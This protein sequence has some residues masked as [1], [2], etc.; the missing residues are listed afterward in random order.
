MK[1]KRKASCRRSLSRAGTRDE[2]AKRAVRRRGSGRGADPDSAQWRQI[3][4]S[5]CRGDDS[6]HP[7]RAHA[8][9]AGAGSPHS[10]HNAAPAS[11]WRQRWHWPGFG[12]RRFRRKPT[13][14][15]SAGGSA[16]YHRGQ[17]IDPPEMGD[18]SRRIPGRKWDL[19]VPPEPSGRMNS[20]SKSKAWGRMCSLQ[21]TPI[22]VDSMSTRNSISRHKSFPVQP[23][24]RDRGT[25]VRTTT[26]RT[27]RTTAGHR[28]RITH[29]F[30]K[31][32][33]AA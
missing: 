1:A 12:S 24:T 17:V 10:G 27:M 7:P 2:R 13:K 23:T 8:A 21:L 14:A 4:R 33:P 20:M 19:G 29:R 16:R 30:S 25:T 31:R 32:T 11:G 3:D 26:M 22:P 6:S 18:R 9:A 15:S 5:L 28:S